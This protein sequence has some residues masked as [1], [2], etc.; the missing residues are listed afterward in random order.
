MTKQQLKVYKYILDHPGCTT[1]DIVRDTF[2]S[3]PSGRITELRGI[4]EIKEVGTVKYPGTK[5]FVK[6]AIDTPLKKPKSTFTYDQA[7]NSMI[8]QVELINI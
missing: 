3:C 4:V 1:R 7:T 5:A 6:Y 8:E 2:V